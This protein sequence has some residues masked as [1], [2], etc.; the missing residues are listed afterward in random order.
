[1]E[2]IFSNKKWMVLMNSFFQFIFLNLLWLLFS[3]PVIT[4]WPATTA[5]FGVTR[6]WV[7]GEEVSI[8]S[9]FKK[10]FIENF[11]LSIITGIIWGLFSFILL[12]DFYFIN[13][14]TTV[15]SLTGL[16]VF[17]I[18]GAIFIMINVYL[19]P[20]LVHVKTNWLGVWRN[21]FNLAISNPFISI[22]NI[23][24]ILIVLYLVVKVP[25]LILGLGS[26]GAYFLYLSV[27]SIFQKWQVEK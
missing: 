4:L 10:L 5:M 6:K 20:V 16:F 22:L 17:G 9:D 12:L 25:I 7:R 8:F 27:N 21:A 15:Y 18:A 1:M 23:G 11:T 19:F 13:H 2:E 26:I 24:I 14:L 3:L